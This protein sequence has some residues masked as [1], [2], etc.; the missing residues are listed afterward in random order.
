MVI[1]AGGGG[2]WAAA[3][4]GALEEDGVAAMEGDGLAASTTAL[5]REW[6]LAGGFSCTQPPQG[7]VT[8]LSWSSGVVVSHYHPAK[9]HRLVQSCW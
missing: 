1:G 4:E 2:T 3:E 7:I 6:H 9:E 5:T 8:S